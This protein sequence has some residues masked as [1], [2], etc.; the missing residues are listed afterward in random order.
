MRFGWSSWSLDVPDDWS[1]IEHAECLS[2]TRSDG[3]L[4]A[5][6]AHKEV[7]VVTERDLLFDEEE[8]RAWGS[9][10]PVQHGKFVGIVYRYFHEEI[11]WR[12]WFLGN[13]P[14]LLFVTY[15]GTIDAAERDSLAVSSILSTLRVEASSDA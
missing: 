15:N 12:R 4:Q 5:S 11:V 3:A 10:K 9:W 8:R 2:V 7:G 6:S 1:V 14:T 13:G